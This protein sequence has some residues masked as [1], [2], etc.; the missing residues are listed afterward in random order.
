[1][2]LYSSARDEITCC[3]ESKVKVYANGSC[4]WYDEYRLSISH[5][6]I[7]ITWFPFDSQVCELVFESINYDSQVLSISTM[8]PEVETKSY[9][10][11]GEWEILGNTST[12]LGYF[13]IYFC[14][15]V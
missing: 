2:L 11:N 3:E 12:S 13:C 15:Q 5:C 14:I 1:M 7:D 4:E 10:E 6:E 8:K 9:T